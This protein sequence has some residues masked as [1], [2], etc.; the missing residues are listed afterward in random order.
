MTESDYRT[1]REHLQAL[2]KAGDTQSLH[3]AAQTLLLRLREA[4]AA[5][6]GFDPV[7]NEIN[8]PLTLLRVTP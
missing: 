4:Q 2:A 8:R 6:L 7:L 1:H 3:H 5:I